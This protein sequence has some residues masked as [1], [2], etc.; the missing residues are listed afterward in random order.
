MAT[1]ALQPPSTIIKFLAIRLT[2][3]YPI[4]SAR[5]FNNQPITGACVDKL[6]SSGPFLR[7]DIG[8]CIC[9]N[10]EESDNEEEED[11][12]TSESGSPRIGN[13]SQRSQSEL[14][15][16]TTL[17]GTTLKGAAALERD[18]REYKEA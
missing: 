8:T 13:A 1:L 4:L 3:E 11:D 15:A 16:P 9:C 7:V 2:S 12:Q 5:I 10:D 17:C 6:L 14:D 18:S